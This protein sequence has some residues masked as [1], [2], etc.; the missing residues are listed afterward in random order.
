MTEADQNLGRRAFL[1]RLA[2]GLG[3][4]LTAAIGVPLVGAIVAPGLR[5]DQAQW[6]PVGSTA[7]FVP[8]EPRL[9]T[10]S[11]AKTDGYVTTSV[12]RAVWV[13]R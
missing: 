2:G 9:V 3:A 5:R 13:Y 12:A 1:S 8:G 6:V 10:F 11:V 7:E 4:F